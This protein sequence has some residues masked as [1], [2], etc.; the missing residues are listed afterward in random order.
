MLCVEVSMR[1]RILP[2]V[3]PPDQYARLEREAKAQERDPIQQARHIL[4]QHFDAQQVDPAHRADQAATV[5]GP[6]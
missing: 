3:L 4:R 1:T 6:K 5:G 2:L